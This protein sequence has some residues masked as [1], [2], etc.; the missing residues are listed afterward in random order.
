MI[1]NTVSVHVCALS[2]QHKESARTKESRGANTD[3]H[4]RATSVL[5]GM[6]INPNVSLH[7]RLNLHQQKTESRFTRI[8]AGFLSPGFAA[9]S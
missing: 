2:T 1:G 7:Q 8:N 4:D 9:G 3:R 6:G 5:N